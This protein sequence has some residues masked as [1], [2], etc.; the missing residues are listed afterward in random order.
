[1]AD[2]GPTGVYISHGGPCGKFSFGVGVVPNPEARDVLRFLRPQ[3]PAAPLR[4]A[5][6]LRALGRRSENRVP[7]PPP[8]RTI[9]KG[10]EAGERRIWSRFCRTPVTASGHVVFV[11]KPPCRKRVGN[12]SGWPGAVAS[13]AAAKKVYSLY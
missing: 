4:D 1:V 6:A 12:Y 13:G 5:E 11:S 10:G 3:A 9:E 2:K 8:G 7:A